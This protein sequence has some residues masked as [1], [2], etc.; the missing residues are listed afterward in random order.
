MDF[1]TVTYE[2]ED[3][4]ATIT[5]NRPERF[6]AIN[7]SMPDDIAAAFAHA[8]E[9]DTVHVVVLTGAGRG[10][11]GGYDLKEYAEAP[12]VNPAIQDMP[13][14]PMIDYRFMGHCTQQF[15]SIWRCHKPVIGRIHGDAVA[16][17]SDI[18]L[19]CDIIIMKEDARI[20]YPPSRV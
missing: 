13:W 2:A 6:N 18:A 8:N 10:F 14:D 15:M 5:L 12:G 11:C 1:N 4:V 19:C 16:G 3:R 9:D 20:G 17:G 7:G